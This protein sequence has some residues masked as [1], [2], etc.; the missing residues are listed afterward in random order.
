MSQAAIGVLSLSFDMVSKVCRPN[1]T[2]QSF[3]VV[4]QYYDK[5]A[6]GRAEQAISIWDTLTSE[7]RF[8]ILSFDV[9]RFL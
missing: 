2:V 4:L 3:G 7:M 5:G 6:D 9:S 8:L 1:F